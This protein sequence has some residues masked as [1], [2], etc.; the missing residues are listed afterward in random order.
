MGEI[1]I[2]EVCLEDSSA[3]TTIP[4]ASGW[5]EPIQKESYTR[6]F[7]TKNGWEEQG[8]AAFFSLTLLA[9]GR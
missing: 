3:I 5:S 6:K 9:P 2:R 7:Y 8:D 4:R 1:T